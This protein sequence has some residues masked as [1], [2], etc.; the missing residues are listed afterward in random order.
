[1]AITAYDLPEEERNRL[2]NLPSQVFYGV[3]TDEAITLRLLGVPRR[4]ATPLARTL[5]LRAGESLPAIRQR[6]AALSQQDWAAAL[7]PDGNAYR[8]VWQIMDGVE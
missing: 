1:M 6:L 4:A 7:G 8:R 5:N 3:S 2:A